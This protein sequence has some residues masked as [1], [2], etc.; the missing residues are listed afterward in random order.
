MQDVHLRDLDLNLLVVLDVL[1][2]ERSVTR[3][4][5][6]LH[7]SQSAVSHALA[8]L[9]TQLDDPLLVRVGA[10]MQ[11]SPRAAAMMAELNR[12]LRS[13]KQVLS[14]HPRFDP[15][16]TTRIFSLMVP[17]LLAGALTALLGRLTEGA[18]GARLEVVRPGPGVA[19]DVRDGRV[20]LALAPG[21]S[22]SRADG[23]LQVHP[24]LPVP[25][26]VFA[27]G[28]HPALE[29]LDLNRWLDWP[30]VVVSTGGAGPGRI[31]RALEGLGRSRRVAVRL[32]SFTMAASLLANSSLLFAAPRIALRPSVEA[33]GLRSA[34]LPLDLPPLRFALYWSRSRERE[35]AL[36]W[37][38]ARALQ[39][40]AELWDQ[41]DSSSR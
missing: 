17:D 26:E 9:R 33:F 18:P 20:D 27:R 22:T 5:S 16:T 12:L 39:V 34:P 31:D 24:F 29:A 11:P 25:W 30:H 19:P 4:A 36:A 13:L 38:R 3:A 2:E 23:P 32:P 35:P 15:A 37:F 6:R 8:R 40:F 41:V 14:S 21:D 28:D 10:E 7:R 1:L